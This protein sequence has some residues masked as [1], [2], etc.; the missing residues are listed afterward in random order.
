MTFADP[1]VEAVYQSLLHPPIGCYQT[2]AH[3]FAKGLGRSDFPERWLEEGQTALNSMVESF[4][5]GFDEAGQDE[6]Y[7]RLREVAVSFQ[8]KF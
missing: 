3:A 6:R 5:K 4:T 8:K 1:Q 2:G 7:K